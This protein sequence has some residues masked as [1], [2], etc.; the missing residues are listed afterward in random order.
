MGAVHNMAQ[1]ALRMTQPPLSL[2]GP[3]RG[4]FPDGSWGGGVLGTEGAKRRSPINNEGAWAQR[5][6]TQS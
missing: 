4:E 5:G 3:S 2:V 1:A 6:P